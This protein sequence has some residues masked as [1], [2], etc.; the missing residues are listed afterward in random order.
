MNYHEKLT[1][2]N[3][4]GWVLSLKTPSLTQT[5]LIRAHKLTHL[6]AYIDNV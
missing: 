6:P 4:T 2:V 3:Q 1:R 5:D